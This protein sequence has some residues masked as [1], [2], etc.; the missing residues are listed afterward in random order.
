MSTVQ[1][2]LSNG[3]TFQGGLHLVA[4]PEVHHFGPFLLD[5]RERRL[6][7]DGIPVP[8]RH[9]VFETLRVLVEGRGRLLTKDVLMQEVW[10][11]VIV[12]ENNLQTNISALRKL[13]G[14]DADGN[15][16]IETVP[17]AGYRL[18]TQIAYASPQQ[19]TSREGLGK[20]S[21]PR[22]RNSI[23]VLYFENLSGEKDDEYFRDG[24]TEDVI[25]ELGKIKGVRVFPR[26]A[27]LALRDQPLGMAKIRDRL[28]A[29]YVVEG[30]IRRAHDRLRVTARLTDTATSHAVW[31]ERYDRNLDDVFAIQDEIAQSIAGALRIVVS[32]Q[33]KRAIKKIPTRDVQAYDY[34]LRGRQVIFQYRRES[35]EFARQMF[36]RATVIDP[37]YAA[38]FAG[39]ADCSAFLYMYFEAS[40]NNLRE[41]NSA[42]LRAVQLD[43]ESAEAHASRG[44]AVSLEHRYEESHREFDLAV[45]LN[46][47]LFQA[48]YYRARAYVAQGKMEL[49]AHAFEQA[50]EVDPNDYQAPSLAGGVYMGLGMKSEADAC[51]RRGLVAAERYLVM[52]PNDARAYYLGALDLF[53]LG[54]RSRSLEWASRALEIE[55]HEPA[56]LYN[57][58]GLYALQG[59]SE[60]AITFLERAIANG[61]SHKQWILHDSD[62]DSLRDEKRFK[63]L[64]R[65]LE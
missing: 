61:Y 64:L 47:A 16:Y 29:A 37:T 55:P 8:L 23:A 18:R 42:S 52:A 60:Q 32:D 12:E 10:P 19:A 53:H 49:A 26:S 24:I 57:I 38:A 48:F 46:P 22:A 11:D 41:A 13:L 28:D 62:L 51:F 31:S 30:S 56:V 6:L 44:L 33:E 5:T 50:S 2:G 20:G 34:Y 40:E 14:E 36:A 21:E 58:S 7:R 65:N 1:L 27:V 15:S 59:H 43:P 54:D 17:R 3:N 25:T 9:R 39:V 63:E 4:Q 45:R 35:M